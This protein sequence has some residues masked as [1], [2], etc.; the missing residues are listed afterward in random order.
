LLRDD[1]S[2]LDL[3]RGAVAGSR[4]GGLCPFRK[5]EEGKQILRLR[6][7]MTTKKQRPKASAEGCFG[8]EADFSTALLTMKL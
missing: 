3:R 2:L 4:E 7:R 1:G 5:D 6:R 8:R